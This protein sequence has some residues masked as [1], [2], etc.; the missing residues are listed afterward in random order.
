M[1]TA[2][3]QIPMLLP[4]IAITF[5]TLN[6]YVNSRW[7]S[8]Y[9]S[10]DLSWLTDPRFIIG[11]SVFFV[12]MRINR[13]SDNILLNLRKPGE[14]GYKIP[15]GGLYRWISSPNYF[16]EIIEWF[17][18]AIATWSLAGLAFAVYAI[19]NLA[20]RALSNH[21]WYKEKFAD[22]PRERRALIPGIW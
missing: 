22:Y 18:W 3:K 4:L 13:Q 12:G 6:A 19:A 17:G 14:S 21:Q 5:N 10:Y 8:H 2:G 16:G 11:A 7:I 20:P 15:E 1:K 9:G